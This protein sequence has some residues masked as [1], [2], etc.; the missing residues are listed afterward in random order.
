MV[1][2]LY[3][4]H[5]HSLMRYAMYFGLDRQAAEDV[6]QQSFMEFLRARP[7]LEVP[8]RELA[9]LRRV[10]ERAAVRALSSWMRLSPLPDE[11]LEPGL[12]TH[13]SAEEEA[14]ANLGTSAVAS[15]LRELPLRQR[16]TLALTME[17]FQP[18][19]IARVLGIEPNA[20][21]VSLHH[22]RTKVQARLALADLGDSGW[23]SAVASV[24]R[25]LPLRQRETLALTMEGF[26]PSEIARVLGIE[27]NAVRMSLHHARAKVQARLTADSAAAA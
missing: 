10:V 3:T 4:A 8:G 15:V 23:A 9:Y 7:I 25:E 11:E 2:E 16:E 6:V 18:S 27:P 21:R 13:A 26:Q 12:G 20:V 19:E 22:A 1:S 5:Y 24:L 17:G 14:V